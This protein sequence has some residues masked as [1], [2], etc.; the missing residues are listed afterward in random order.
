MVTAVQNLFG[1]TSEA[2]ITIPFIITQLNAGQL[3]VARRTK[4]LIGH[5]ETTTAIGVDG[6][7]VPEDFIQIESLTIEGRTIPHHSM[8]TLDGLNPTRQLDSNGS[9]LS[10]YVKGRTIFLYPPPST[11][12]VGALDIWYIKRPADLIANDQISDLPIT[13]HD[14]VVLFALARCKELDEEYAQAQVIKQDYRDRIIEG[15]DEVFD[16]YADTYPSIRLLSGD[17]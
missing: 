3:D 4:C 6:Y 12:V 2:Q 5:S 17:Y 14:D 8:H 1:D 7:E 16:E 11:S 13:M 9:T 10:Y 15:K